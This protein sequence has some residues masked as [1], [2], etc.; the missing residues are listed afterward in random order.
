M[1][2]QFGTANWEH[3]LALGIHLHGLVADDATVNRAEASL[4]AGEIAD[5]LP[6]TYHR[7]VAELQQR[8]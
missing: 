8:A 2:A 6:A 5:Y 7:F 3:A 4:L 1:A